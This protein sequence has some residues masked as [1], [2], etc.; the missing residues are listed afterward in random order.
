MTLIPFMKVTDF[1]IGIGL[2]IAIMIWMVIGTM[3]LTAGMLGQGLEIVMML[4]TTMISGIVDLME[5]EKIAGKEIMILVGMIM[6]LIKIEEE[7]KVVGE[8]MILVNWI[9]ISEA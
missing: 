5:V 8:G 9:E 6:N 2:L 4:V 3:C 7:G 1:M